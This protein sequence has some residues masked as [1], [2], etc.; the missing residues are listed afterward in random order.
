MELFIRIKNGQ[1]FEHPILGSNFRQAFPEID[2]DNLP[3]EFVRFERIEQPPTGVYE[4]YEGLTYEWVSGIVKDVFHIRSMTEKEKIEK[5]EATKA[6]F[7]NYEEEGYLFNEE[8]CSF[9][10][11][12]SIGVTRV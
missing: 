5:Q 2:T 12:N 8:T 9:V 10:F 11:K 7:P 4:V 3:P 1:P 6:N